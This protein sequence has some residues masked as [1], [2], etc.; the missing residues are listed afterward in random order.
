MSGPEPTVDRS[1]SFAGP[2]SFRRQIEAVK[3]GVRIEDAALDYGEFRLAGAGRLLGRCVSPDHEDKTPSMHIFTDDQ[4][5][6]CFGIGC[7]AHGDV[8]DLV[9]LAEGCELWV[10]MVALSQRYGIELPERPG[11]WYEKQKRQAPVRDRIDAERVEHLRMLVFRLIW[12]PWLRQ[13]P[14][15][16]REEAAE[17]AWAE[18][19]PIALLLYEQRRGA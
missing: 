4:H 7:G 16:V 2:A 18:S 3:D 1:G 10:A 15:W 19:R 5:F 8:L 14:E 6:K 11:S 12:M 9:M 13:L 17:R